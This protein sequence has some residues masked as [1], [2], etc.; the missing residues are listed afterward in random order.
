MGECVPAS[1][2]EIDKAMQGLLIQLSSC[3][4]LTVHT[5]GDVQ[6]AIKMFGLENFLLNQATVLAQERT[7]T[8]HI[9]NILHES[10]EDRA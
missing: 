8:R 9:H 7:Y 6:E 5:G 4:A 10:M 2:E 1:Q 3:K